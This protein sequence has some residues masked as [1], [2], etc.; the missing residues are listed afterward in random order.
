MAIGRFAELG[1]RDRAARE[2]FAVQSMCQETHVKEA[3]F[4]PE[5]KRPSQR[6]TTNPPKARVRAKAEEREI[7]A[8]SDVYQLKVLRD[9]VRP[10]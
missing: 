9:Q 8:T 6:Q 3:T 1:K 5:P 7:R 4:H 10:L 2:N